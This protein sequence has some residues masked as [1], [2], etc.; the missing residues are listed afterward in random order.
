MKNDF[1]R[2]DLFSEYYRKWIDIYKRGAVRDVTLRK[3]EMT[4]QWIKNIAPA[5]KVEQLNR[6]NYQTIIN[7]YAAYHERQTTMD[8]HHQLKGAI[9]DAL[10]EGL[11][12]RD[13]TRK[14]VIKGRQPKEKKAK[15]LN[16][17]QLH[18]L[19]E[20]LQLDRQCH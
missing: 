11:I 16:Q 10:D 18:A 17:F 3:Y 6:L 13:P 1:D 9:L 8:F 14:V 20:D 2:Q 4:L 12:D 7:E 15:Y 5:L 19:L